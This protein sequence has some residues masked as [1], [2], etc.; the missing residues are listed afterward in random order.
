VAEESDRQ[1]GLCES[2][3]ELKPLVLEDQVGR[4]YCQDCVDLAQQTVRESPVLSFMLSTVPF[5]VGD[6]VE[7]RTAEVLY[8][9]IGTIDEV[10]MEIE[11][12]GTPFHPAFHVVIE[13]KAYP[14]APDDV[15][16]MERQLK[17]V[18]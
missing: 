5:K 13:E 1:V 7:C 18:S 10:S 12:F 17:K 15:W 8:D 6:R 9:G 14:E 3:V 2:C 16:Y 4:G 11:K